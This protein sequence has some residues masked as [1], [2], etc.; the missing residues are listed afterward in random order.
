MITL[1]IA[2]GLALIGTLHLKEYQLDLLLNNS[3]KETV[4]AIEQASRISTINREQTSVSYLPASSYLVLN[5]IH[6]H[7]QIELDPRIKIKNLQDFSISRNGTI[8]PRTIEF[9]NGR[10]VKKIKIQMTWGRAIEQ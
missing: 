2:C 8:S 10:K 3:V 4:T 6:F 5:G 9:T 1:I 7:R